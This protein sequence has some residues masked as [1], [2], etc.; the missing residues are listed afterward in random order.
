[1]SES[2]AL[3]A[4]VKHFRP[5]AQPTAAG[6]FRSDQE[7]KWFDPDTLITLAAAVP[8]SNASAIQG[9]FTTSR[10]A[11]AHLRV[12]RNYMGHRSEA[13]NRD[14]LR[15]G[16]TYLAGNPKRP[17][18]IV[19]HVE[20]AHVVSVVERWSIQIRQVAVYLCS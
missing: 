20:A 6:G 9:A 16:P 12:M 8:L 3:H 10:W 18:D 14:A 15:L 2:Q 13:L 11:F 17:S 7:P 19:W 4:A 5:H 1:M